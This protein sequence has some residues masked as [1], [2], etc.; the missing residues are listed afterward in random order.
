MAEATLLLRDVE[1][2]GRTGLDLVIAGDRILAIGRSLGR[3]AVEIDGRGGALIPGLADNHIHLLAT[4][5][6]L[7]SIVLDD[8]RDVE[9]LSRRVRGAARNRAAGTWLRA[10][11][12]HEHA[13]GPLSRKMLDAICPDHPLRVQHQSG[14]MWML[15]TR[16]LAIVDCDAEPSPLERDAAGE[17]TGRLFRADDWL[18]ARIGATPPDLARVGRSLAEYGITHVTDASVS[19]EGSAAALLAASVRRGEIK[20]RLTLMSGGPL[21]APSDGAFAVGPVKI[22]LEDHDL[23]PLD[24]IIGKIAQARAWGRRVAVHCVTAGE[25]AVTLAAFEAAGSLPGDR[26][27]HGSIIPEEAIEAIRTL[28]LTVVTQPV[29]VLARGDRYRALVTPAERADLYRCASLLRNGIPVFASSDAPYGDVDPWSAMRAAIHRRTRS[30]AA[31]APDESIDP[32][33]ALSLFRH[34]G[35]AQPRRVA[36]GARADLCLLDTPLATVLAEPDAKRVKAT[37]YRGRIAY[38][39][40]GCE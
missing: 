14:A 29:F 11:G 6:R 32:V 8:V 20:A 28:G 22:L 33:T 4:A 26:I 12:Y 1:I 17:A 18:R 25:L 27:E 19:T 23:P 5:A 34:A 16:A 13:A 15:N 35:D 2:A 30:G 7:E 38:A 37:I 3:A 31:L 39:R 40:A 9:A 24:E 10:T 21:E 36:V